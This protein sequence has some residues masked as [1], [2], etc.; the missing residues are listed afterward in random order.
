RAARARA[1]AA[2]AGAGYR[3]D[4][5]MPE[6]ALLEKL[7][8]RRTK[9]LELWLTRQM[10]EGLV[11][12]TRRL[13]HR[14][15]LALGAGIGTAAYTLFPRYRRV[16][17]K[18]LAH[19]YG[20]TWSCRQIEAT[21]RE[22]FRNV[23]R[24]LVEFARLPAMPPEE[25]ERLLR[26]E[27]LEH[28]DAA[29]AR[30]RGALLISAHYGNWELLAAGASHRGYKLNVIARPFGHAALDATMRGIRARGGSAVVER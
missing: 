21:A 16:A 13:S 4:G 8:P 30:G 29:L 14:S 1:A 26:L 11:G 27:S 2:R 18:N 12:L 20:D 22:T 15:A 6:V 7:V 5:V 24:S 25:M 23:G 9:P 19:V 10:L 17:L 28:L 3:S